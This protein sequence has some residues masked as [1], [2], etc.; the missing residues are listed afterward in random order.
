[1][2]LRGGAAKALAVVGW[3]VFVYVVTWMALR[4]PLP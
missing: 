1:M 3:L 2:R 4:A